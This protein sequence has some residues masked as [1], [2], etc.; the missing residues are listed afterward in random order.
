MDGKSMDIAGDKLNQL[1]AILP[2]AFTENKIDWEKLRAAL[3]D[4]IEFKNERYVLNWAGKSDAFRAL[5]APSTATLSPCPEESVY[6]EQSGNVFIEGENLE[7]LKALQKSYFGKIKMIYID[8]PYNTGNDH[9][10]YP[11]RFSESRED[12]LSRIGDK[13]ETGLMTREGLFRKNSKD[14]GHY[15]SNWLSMMYPRLFL[16]RNLLR[17]DGVI[18]VSIDDNEVHNLRLLMN[19]VFGEENFSGNFLWHRR[20]RADSRNQSNVST[21]HEYIVAYSKSENAIQKGVSIDTEKYGNPDNDP[22]GPWASIDLSGLA[23][24]A[25]RP[26]LHY[27][28]VDPATGNVYPPNPTRGWSKSKENVRKMIGEGRILF[29]KN[30][31]GRPR[32][33]K[34]LND[35]LTTITGFS[36]CLDSKVVGYTTN[37]TREVTEIFKGKYFDFP[38]PSTLIKV[39]IEQASSI[40]SQ[41]IILDFFAGSCTTAHAVLELNREDGGNRKFIC[42]QLPEKCDENTEAYKAGYSTIAEIGKE[43]IRRVIRKISD[44]QSVKLDLDGRAA[45]QDLGFKVFKLRES[46]FK[47]W[48][49][50]IET[51]EDLV[52]QMQQ[53]LEPLDEHAKIEDILYEL[54][55]KAGVP[56]TAD[57]RAEEGFLLANNGE[58]AL[59]LERADEDV[60]KK[61]LAMKPQKVFTLD[62]LFKQNDKL[63]TNTALQMKDA[64]IE[65]KVI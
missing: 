18:F 24:A 21:D 17:D 45:S 12:Y 30:P 36:T 16:A 39:F 29:P 11:D 54:L 49:T 40:N 5:Q 56:L 10:I 61:I 52:A 41:D 22:R 53:H 64:G 63:K 62:R 42:V 47:I 2:E 28:I 51:E 35:L 60:I 38:K 27:D 55:L 14:G 8:P 37:G 48:R 25:Q 50:A 9:F 57:I 34:F 31:S 32:E 3:G 19:E 15:H 26:N 23:T 43:R 4:N 6:F 13:D 46:N 7:V 33:K 1:K 65:F 44:D 59:A 20:Q 58:I